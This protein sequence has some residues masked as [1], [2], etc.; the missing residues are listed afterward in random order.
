MS[1]FSKKAFFALVGVAAM[2]V[3]FA[4]CSKDPDPVPNPN[5]NP[6]KPPVVTDGENLL[7]GHWLESWSKVEDD[8]GFGKI[9]VFEPSE[10][11]VYWEATVEKLTYWSLWYNAGVAVYFDLEGGK[12][13]PI[14][15]NTKITLTYE[16]DYFLHMVLEGTHDDAPYMAVLPATNGKTT[17]TLDL[18][19][20][21][22]FWEE[23]QDSE[24][25]IDPSY[26]DSSNMHFRIP[27]WYGDAV[28][29]EYNLDYSKIEGIHF[30]LPADE[31]SA[32]STSVDIT[33]FQVID[34]NFGK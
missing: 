7:S 26:Y 20:T 1:I 8:N 5:P 14:T 15:N 19:K 29:T 6:P 13:S 31:Y 24:G 18:S 21:G 9:T 11:Q 4:G 27:Y 32:I 3:M 23:A 10:G 22:G 33:K 17:I 30:I 12:A 25:D 2:C 28:D 16:S 34:G